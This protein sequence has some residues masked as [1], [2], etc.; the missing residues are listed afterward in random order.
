[1]NG[2]RLTA[3]LQRIAEALSVSQRTISEDLRGLKR[4]APHKLTKPVRVRRN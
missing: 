1:M 3:I 2:E 4:D